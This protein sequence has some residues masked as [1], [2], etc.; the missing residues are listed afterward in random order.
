MKYLYIGY[1][2]KICKGC[3]LLMKCTKCGAE[4]SSKDMFC[5]NCGT[6]L[7]P[8][9]IAIEQL[10]TLEE[11]Y[12]SKIIEIEVFVQ[13]LNDFNNILIK[14]T[15][16]MEQY[17]HLI[18]INKIFEDN[19]GLILTTLKDINEL[20]IFQYL[21]E[22]DHKDINKSYMQIFQA[23]NKLNDF[24]FFEKKK[25]IN[26]K[27]E[28]LY[29]LLY[30]ECKIISKIISS[31]INDPIHQ[32]YSQKL[33]EFD[34]FFG[35]KN[36]FLL[37]LEYTY[38]LVINIK[39]SPIMKEIYNVCR[40]NIQFN[41]DFNFEIENNKKVFVKIPVKIKYNNEYEK[42]DMA[43]IRMYNLITLFNGLE[44]LK[45]K[46][47]EKF[48]YLI[49][50]LIKEHSNM[51][52]RVYGNQISFQLFL[53][54]E[55]NK[56]ARGWVKNFVKKIFNNKITYTAKIDSYFKIYT[57]FFKASY[58][59]QLLEANDGNDDFINT[60]IHELNHLLDKK[61]LK[62][63]EKQIYMMR[64]EKS[65]QFISEN[66]QKNDLFNVE[67]IRDE[68]ITRFSEFIHGKKNIDINYEKINK[69]RNKPINNADDF[70]YFKNEEHFDEYDI[71]QYILIT[72]WL[73]QLSLNNETK[74]FLEQ[75]FHNQININDLRNNPRAYK[76]GEMVLNIIQ[77]V[78]IIKTFNLYLK[79][80][81]G[82]PIITESLINWL[83][84]EY[85]KHDL[86]DDLSKFRESK[87]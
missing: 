75:Y 24:E 66:Q 48:T 19:K 64:R 12:F 44:N 51:F 28:Y 13:S 41:I 5:I 50:K 67:G 38:N 68:G 73:R 2:N 58:F 74:I 53:N 81:T 25:K 31:N 42:D 17:A 3:V 63:Q 40:T 1:F 86:N 61:V 22:F 29:E 36:E 70:S 76:V 39:N 35:T 4:N 72:I 83:K 59:E 69:L 56:F 32:H 57:I 52:L 54:F 15:S 37:S 45:K 23:I 85:N 49:T 60:F 11:K 62:S 65:N 80:E 87:F 6:K 71:G 55:E 77:S 30:K 82:A 18:E 8:L 43:L 33:K 34:K 26:E 78:D 16:N 27:I 46:A 10:K 47:E 84:E 21:K 14:N 7:N 79:S 9:E 20:N